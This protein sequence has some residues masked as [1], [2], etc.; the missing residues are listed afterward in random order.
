MLVL[1][2]EEAE[3]RLALFRRTNGAVAVVQ[4]G[5]MDLE[6][7]LSVSPERFGSRLKEFLAKQGI[8]ERKTAVLLPLD[9]FLF[10]RVEAP[11]LQGDDLH[12]FLEIEAEQGFPFALS[13]LVW[14]F[15]R[16]VSGRLSILMAAIQ[17]KRER[18]LSAALESAGLE[19]VSL[20]PGAANVTPIDRARD[21]SLVVDL[22]L[23]H[24][25]AEVRFCVDG[26]LFGLRSFDLHE[27]DLDAS[28]AIKVLEREFRITLGQLPTASQANASKIGLHGAAS[29]IE[30]FAKM[31]NHRLCG[32][33]LEKASYVGNVTTPD[34]AESV[35]SSSVSV[36]EAL[37]HGR[38]VA[39]EL[40]PAKIHPLEQLMQRMAA[41]K[42][43][44]WGG[45]AA[46]L[47]LLTSVLFFMQGRKLSA[48]ESEWEAIADRVAQ[49]EQL[50][51]NVRDSKPGL[52]DPFLS[53]NSPCEHRSLS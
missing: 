18:S 23:E 5:R 10:H 52:M 41:G 27:V 34:E 48:A 17:K 19:M 38:A 32:I 53:L 8:Q 6:D 22:S 39:L 4:N 46:G 45:L 20:T 49:I 11:E 37:L 36:G 50:R 47:V 3:V 31:A 28:K 14:T 2:V 1:Q 33:S 35:R 13:D 15:N 43:K 26:E 30:G 9:W 16:G 44:T 24:A 51:Q 29:D 21:A 42:L 25:K 12:S 40:M 7:P